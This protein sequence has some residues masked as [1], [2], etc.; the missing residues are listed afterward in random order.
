LSDTLD[1]RSGSAITGHV[2]KESTMKK[3]QNSLNVALLERTAAWIE[4]HPEH[5]DMGRWVRGTLVIDKGQ[6][7]ACGTTGCIAGTAWALHHGFIRQ[8]EGS[9]GRADWMP[10]HNIRGAVLASMPSFTR[11]LLCCSG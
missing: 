6:E 10:A 11:P 7:P 2:I 1:S 5:F 8:V 9:N 3:Q 4:A